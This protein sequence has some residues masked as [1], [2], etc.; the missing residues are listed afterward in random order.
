MDCKVLE[1]SNVMVMV[2]A[3]LFHFDDP[4]LRL[5]GDLGK[6]DRFGTQH[7]RQGKFSFS[8]ISA[9]FH[10]N[11]RRSL[12]FSIFNLPRQSDHR[13]PV[14]CLQPMVSKI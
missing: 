7:F 11:S 3:F 12:L 6:I 8:H 5:V 13:T 9:A 10:E 2:V 1:F 4:N 14:F